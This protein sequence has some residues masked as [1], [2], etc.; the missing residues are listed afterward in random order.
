MAAGWEDS[1]RR[2]EMVAVGRGRPGLRRPPHVSMMQATDFG[3][4]HDHAKLRPVD[5]PDVWRILL[6][7]EVSSCTVIVG[8][9]ACQDAAQVPLAQNENMVQTLATY[10]ANEPLR[11]GILPRAVGGRENL[12]DLHA[13]HS[14]PEGVAVEL[15]AI[16]EEIG[17]R[18]VVREGVHDLLGRPGGGGMLGQV[19]VEDAPALVGE[20]DQDEEDA[21]AS[22]GNG[23]EIDRDEVADMVSEEGAP[24]L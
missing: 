10:R 8:E 24:G 5:R 13:L 23:K 16:A 20:H 3:N 19:K 22:G 15:V 18:G 17:G 1:P 6:E 7:R 4:R 21:Q 14:V 9:V 12:S 2:G 11:E